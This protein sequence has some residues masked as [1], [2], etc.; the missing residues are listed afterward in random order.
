MCISISS[1]LVTFL[2]DNPFVD[3]PLLQ[4]LLEVTR[5]HFFRRCFAVF[6]DGK[7]GRFVYKEDTIP[8]VIIATDFVKVVPFLEKVGITT[9]HDTH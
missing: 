8:Y 1:G 4:K 9:E 5:C 6:I 2:G 3:R 7:Q